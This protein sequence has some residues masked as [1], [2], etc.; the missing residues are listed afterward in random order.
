M[1]AEFEN[2]TPF[3]ALAYTM[4]DTEDRAYHVLA[5]R[6]T[7]QLEADA[8]MPGSYQ[9]RVLD[10]AAPPLV[11]ED[12]YFGEMNRS[13]VRAESDLAPYKPKCDVI[14]N[15]TAHAPGGTPTPRFEVR[16]RVRTPDSPAPLPEPPRG[17]N[18]FQQASAKD[19]ADWRRAVEHAR[20]H[21]VEGTVLIDKRLIIT[22]ERGF[23]QH[24][25]PLRLF[26]WAVKWASLGLIRHNPWKLTAPQKLTELP[27]R[28]ESAFGGECRINLDDQ[29]AE[30]VPKKQRLTP[31]QQ[32]QHPEQPSPVAHTVCELNPIG[33][34]YSEAWYLQATKQTKIPAPQIESRSAP[35]TAPLFWR[36]L[37][38]KLKNATPQQ[39]A[40]FIPAGFGLIGRPWLPRRSRAGT[41]DQ[42]WLDNR[43]PY[44][45]ADFDF[46]YW[47]GAPIDQQI[48]ELPLNALISLTNLTPEGELHTQLPGHRA[49]LLA[50]FEDGAALPIEAAIDTLSIDTDSLTLTCVWRTLLPKDLPIARLEARFETDPQAPLLKYVEAHEPPSKAPEVNPEPT[51][52][53]HK[54]TAWPT[55]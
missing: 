5:M 43:H 14:V 38:G 51:P 6:V 19:M 46:A 17:L 37:N 25:W 11:V 8:A 53:K 32:A 1:A 45:P 21:P 34:G 10:T 13:S 42:A 29:A 7:Y 31:E 36:A 2:L 35:I 48:P 54:E 40:A 15:A 22:G 4:L 41:Y 52:P 20:A 27:L 23:T 24:A 12:Q 49:F 9:A 30:R 55:T 3:P 44:L 18:P 28:Y 50:W 26:W 39:L 16:L 47:N 33:Q